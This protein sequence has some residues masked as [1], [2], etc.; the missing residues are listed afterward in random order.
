MAVLV[1]LAVLTA[2]GAPAGTAAATPPP[3][4]SPHKYLGT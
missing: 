3:P 4:A 2:A 1:G